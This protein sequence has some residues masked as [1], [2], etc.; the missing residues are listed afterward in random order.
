MVSRLLS[1]VAL[2]SIA[3]LALLL[4]ACIARGRPTD[5]GLGVSPAASTSTPAPQPRAALSPAAPPVAADTV[6][7]PSAYIRMH[8]SDVVPTR[9][10]EAVL[11]L[12]EKETIA[13][14]IF[15]G[16]SEATS[17][18]LRLGKRRYE[19]PLTHDLLDSLMRELGAQLLKVQIDDLKGGTF[20]GSIFIRSGGR[21]FELDARPSDAIALAIGDRAPI[22]VACRVIEASAIPRS[23]LL[24]TPQGPESD[25]Q[26]EGCPARTTP[27]QPVKTTAVGI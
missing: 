8:A 16:G 18:R 25:L 5:R 4:S 7:A 23:S 22:F 12:D 24:D 21:V 17:I 6:T 9:E 11:L 10:G 27:G 20:L 13:I 3:V 15:I 14:P 26:V 1:A 2:A 19:R